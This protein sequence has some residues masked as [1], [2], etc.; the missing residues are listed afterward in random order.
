VSEEQQINDLMREGLEAARSGDRATARDRFTQITELDEN[1]ERAW[2]YL[3]KVVESED[4]K[5]V[6]LKNILVINPDNERAREDLENLE[7]KQRARAAA[8]EVIPGISRRQLMLI[9]GGGGAIIAIIVLIFAIAAISNASQEARIRAEGTA[10]AQAATGTAAAANAEATVIF[11]TQAAAQ[12]VVTAIPTRSISTL[13]PEFTPS[14]SPTGTATPLVE[15][16]PPADVA[17]NIVAFG[18]V[19]VLSNGALELYLY[20]ANG[21]EPTRIGD[22]LGRNVRFTN[23]GSRVIYTRFFN[24][25]FDFGVETVNING[26]QPQIIRS[27][28]GVLGARQPDHCR[29]RN[30]VAFVAVPGDVPRS[31]EE[32]TFGTEPARQLYVIDLDAAG[33]SAQATRRLTN[34]TA[35]YSYPAFAPDCSRIVVARDDRDSLQPGVD[36]VSIAVDNPGDVRP[37]TTDANTYAETTPRFSADG[38]WIVFAAAPR[39]E[40]NNHDV[41]IV[42]ANGAGVPQ[43]A[44]R[45]VS[46][47]IYPVLSPDGRYLAFSSNRQGV[48]NIF[49]LE[50]ASGQ[51][52]QLTNGTNDVFMGD[53]WQ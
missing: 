21:G 16:T 27:E 49:I 48:Y 30:L 35:D 9:G 8:E 43:V 24:T 1:N 53:W 11:E 14:P 39:T 46:D 10:V 32:L 41:V 31:A 47:D 45:D 6:C 33:S 5:R 44:V 23:Q 3:S 17:G 20:A 50:R 40:P 26:S 15:P 37:I 12:L 34:D 28:Q 36:L 22:E 29:S 42:D 18:G 7:R 13:P 19:D 38:Q 25:T 2:Y 51:L 52:W 4:E